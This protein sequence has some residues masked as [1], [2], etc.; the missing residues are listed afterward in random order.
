M[1][2]SAALVGVPT[3]DVTK[4]RRANG[5]GNGKPSSDSETLADHIARSSPAER[6]AAARTVGVEALWST[7]IEPIVTV[8]AE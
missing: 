3:L 5:N 1:R 2:Q 6:V 8:E 7:M 4:A